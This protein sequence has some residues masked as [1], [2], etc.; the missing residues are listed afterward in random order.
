M[1]L[2]VA[3]LG[4]FGEKMPWSLFPL[5]LLG[6]EVLVGSSFEINGQRGYTLVLLRTAGE[7][8][9][10][11]EI[12]REKVLNAVRFAVKE[13]GAELV[14]LGAL[15]KSVTDSG[16]WIVNEL[17]RQGESECFIT[18]GDTFTA[19]VTVEA[20]R[21]V[22]ELRKLSLNKVTIGIV[23]AYG[24]IGD[25]VTRILASQ[26]ANLILIGRR[27][28]GFERLKDLSGNYTMSIDLSDVR[29]AEIVITVTNH[30]TSLLS[31]E[32]LKRGAIVI[33][34]AVP[35]NVSR[36][37]LKARPDIIRIDGGLVK[38]A[39]IDLKVNMGVPKNKMYA[40]VAEAIM[41]ALEG[42][43]SHHVGYVDLN[44][45]RKTEKW[46]KKWGFELAPFTCFGKPIQIE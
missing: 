19:A 13:L 40:C 41:Q 23:G 31:P 28:E 7:M 45:L 3:I 29:E 37:L 26:G 21:K 30:P 36:E 22:C 15:T 1:G 38:D 18:N 9:R 32:H 27:W 2:N 25:A 34:V 46:A 4:N 5:R 44:F 35:P 16:I 6:R 14:L 11:K 33:D 10:E 20:V 24:T 42:E 43:K 12:S 39:G 8:M 17:L